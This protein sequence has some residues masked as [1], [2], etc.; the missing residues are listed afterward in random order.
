MI[1]LRLSARVCRRRWWCL[2]GV[3]FVLIAGG[4]CWVGATG[5]GWMMQAA[6]P[7]DGFSALRADAGMSPRR[8]T[9]LFEQPKRKAKKLPLMPASL[10][11][12]A[13]RSGQPA[14][15]VHG[16]HRIT[17]YAPLALRSNRR[18][19]S[20]Y[21]ALHS[22]VQSQPTPCA[23]RRWQ[24]G[25]GYQTACGSCGREYGLLLY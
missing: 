18:G 3:A 1:F 15:L 6:C 8:A 23:P 13:L 24:K 7:I 5:M 11:F 21:E 12:V 22:A 19:E 16:L 14:V 2:R 17:H 25:V 20:D 9:F 4:V 10:R